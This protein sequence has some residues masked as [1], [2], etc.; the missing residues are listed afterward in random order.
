[1]L[2]GV[3]LQP[4]I[5]VLI[6]FITIIIIISILLAA[7]NR[8]ENIDTASEFRIRTLYGREDGASPYHLVQNTRWLPS[9]LLSRAIR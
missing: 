9:S 2:S 6:T 3:Y 7:E 4:G 5:E 8:T 1:M